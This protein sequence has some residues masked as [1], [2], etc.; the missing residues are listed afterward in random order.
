MAERNLG[1]KELDV[2]EIDNLSEGVVPA[3]PVSNG[4]ARNVALTIDRI[5]PFEN[6]RIPGNEVTRAADIVTQL[7]DTPKGVSMLES[8]TIWA[9]SPF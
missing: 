7:Q 6:H 1:P 2:V 3:I 4:T 9:Y 8:S 5:S